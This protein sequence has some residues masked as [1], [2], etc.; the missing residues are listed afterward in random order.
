M[1]D[2]VEKWLKWKHLG[3]ERALATDPPALQAAIWVC[4]FTS[5]M[6]PLLPLPFLPRR[7]TST[8]SRSANIACQFHWCRVHV[9]ALV[10]VIAKQSGV[11]PGR[12]LHMFAPVC[13]WVCVSAWMFVRPRAQ[14]E[15]TRWRWRGRGGFQ[16]RR[17]RREWDTGEAVEKKLPSKEIFPFILSPNHVS[18]PLSLSLSLHS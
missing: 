18:L 14:A 12:S 6:H 17:Q 15:L 4:F 16:T 8:L 7:H 9:C 11:K 1:L 13:V 5:K 10:V 3:G 2:N